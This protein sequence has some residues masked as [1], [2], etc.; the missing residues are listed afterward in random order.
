MHD[1][2]LALEMNKDHR[3]HPLLGALLYDFCPAAAG[4]WMAGVTP[5]VKHFDIAWKT[6]E[7]YASGITL[8]EGLKK[9][10]VE[11]LAGAVKKYLGEIEDYRRHFPSLDSPERLSIFTG[12]VVDADLRFGHQN[13]F[14]ENFG[15][16]WRNVL[17]YVRVWGFVLDSWQKVI[18]PDLHQ[19]YTLELEELAVRTRNSG[20]AIRLPAFV[21][22]VKIG[23]TTQPHIGFITQ[24]AVQDQVRFFLGA[25]SSPKGN[26]PW[27]GQP[28]MYSLDP[29]TG[30]VKP[31]DAV[32]DPRQMGEV[33]EKL[34]EMARQGPYPPL[35]ALHN[36]EKCTQCIFHSQCYNKSG[37]LS[38]FAVR[39]MDHERQSAW[40]EIAS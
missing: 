39:M 12:G 14:D 23:Y 21:W 27:D 24:G 29:L 25:I 32:A 37:L 26:K 9:N 40:K 2:F 17:E 8:L 4:W 1:L 34:S 3:E 22:K 15:G 18:V 35:N 16:N 28:H 11:G 19:E 13:A 38:D 31:Y 36:P 30:K 5:R 10:G 20:F 33:I 7:D 6:M